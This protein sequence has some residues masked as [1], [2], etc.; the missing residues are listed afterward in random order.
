LKAIQSGVGSAL[1][2]NINLVSSMIRSVRAITNIPIS[3]KIRLH[4]QDIRHTVDLISQATAAGVNFITIHGRT[5]QQR[6]EPPN[7]EAIK[8]VRR[9]IPPIFNALACSKSDD[10]SATPGIL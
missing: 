8:M 3:I 7:I 6:K 2:D 10:I 5:P 1:L 9:R 4:S